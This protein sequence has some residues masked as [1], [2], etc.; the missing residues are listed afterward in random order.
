LTG[1]YFAE[2]RGYVVCS[3]LGLRSFFIGVVLSGFPV[4][5]SQFFVG[6]AVGEILIGLTRPTFWVGVGL[7]HQ[8]FVCFSEFLVG[9]S[10]LF[11]CAVAGKEC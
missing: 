10:H 11:V 6:A 9:L 3:T 4:G 7:T 2:P 1:N 8:F 5:L